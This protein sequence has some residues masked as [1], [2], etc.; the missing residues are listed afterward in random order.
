VTERFDEI[1]DEARL[2]RDLDAARA[3]VWVSGLVAEWGDTDDLLARLRESR[4]PAAI[5]VACALTAIEP[6]A[7]QVAAALVEAGAG[8]RPPWASAV[9]TARPEQAW[10]IVDPFSGNVSV[11]VE[12]VD[13]DEVRHSMLVEIEDSLA[14]DIHFGP[15][16][17]VEDAF[18]ESDTRSLS[19]TE[20]PLTGASARM[21]DAL[22]RTAA[23]PDPP[24]TDEFDMNLPL[25]EAR[26]AAAPAGAELTGPEGSAT[27]V[28][29]GPGA[30]PAPTEAAS[31][32]AGRPP[33]RPP[34]D[35]DDAEADA[36]AAATLRAALTAARLD[37]PA[38]ASLA[39]AAAAVRASLAAHDAGDLEALAADTGL[40][41]PQ[42][43]DDVTLLATLAGAFVV[44]GALAAFSPAE[45]EALRGLEWADWLGAVIPLVRGGAGA[46]A[47][48][49]QLVHNINR[50]PEV[51]TTVPKR[52]VPV[53][54]GI[55][56]HT[57]HAWELTGVIDAD[58]RLT[59]LGA[60]LLPRALLQ[61]WGDPPSGSG[62]V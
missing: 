43:V 38:P 28:S 56:A 34:R 11:V 1:L 12:L 46:E 22:A 36:A 10:E 7:D 54:A 19:V 18:D 55:F 40:A 52:D 15:P 2:L 62:K 20:L 24:V 49:L 41:D 8:I 47:T 58:S 61:A 31:A 27:P 45:R 9:G 50:C 48:P 5:D 3:E 44:P 57:L 42:S 32:G 33:G 25:A 21:R 13:I 39:P 14:V 29:G 16:G 30:A 23:H 6:A 59:E 4:A 60:W 35:P 53:V 37:R 17:L 26:L 51:T